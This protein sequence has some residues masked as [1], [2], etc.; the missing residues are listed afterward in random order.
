VLARLLVY[1]RDPVVHVS[2]KK[3]H[4]EYDYQHDL[5]VYARVIQLMG[6]VHGLCAMW[7]ADGEDHGPDD[8]S[9]DAL[10]IGEATAH[11]VGPGH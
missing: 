8:L 4:P 1:I 5:A 11:D 10:N 6:E 3:G 9:F 2:L 7:A